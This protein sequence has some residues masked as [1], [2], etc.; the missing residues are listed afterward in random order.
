MNMRT[1]GKTQTIALYVI[2][3]KTMADALIN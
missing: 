3:G 1:T 2:S